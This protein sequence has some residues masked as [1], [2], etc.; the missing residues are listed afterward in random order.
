MKRLNLGSGP[1][2]KDGVGSSLAMREG[3]IIEIYG[4]MAVVEYGALV[5]GLR[6]YEQAKFIL[7]KLITVIEK[8][9]GTEEDVARTRMYVT[10]IG[11]WKKAGRAHGDFFR[12]IKPA[13]S[14]VPV[15]AFIAPKYMI[16]IEAT[17]IINSFDE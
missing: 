6:V 4:T 10:N 1:P 13:T 5:S 16:E 17:A 11:S 15:C 9:C 7:A 8:A 3:N 14:M 12:D 2:W